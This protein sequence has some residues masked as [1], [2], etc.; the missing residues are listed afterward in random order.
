VRTALILAAGNGDRFR[1]GTR[2]SKLLQTVL[3]QPLILR[4]LQTAHEAGIAGFEIVLGYQADRVRALIDRGGPAGCPVHFTYNPAW[5]LENGVSVL[6]ARARLESVRFALLMG[7]HLFE[8]A[9]L[10]RLLRA[11]LDAGE[12]VLAVD[13]RAV[14]PEVAAEATKVRLNGSHILEIGK[15]LLEYDALDTGLFVCAPPLFDALVRAQQK[16][17]TTLSGGIR[18]LAALGLMRALDIG[19]AAWCDIDTTDDLEVAETMF[20]REPEHV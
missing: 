8:P 5:H 17:D 12:S 3:G 1:N 14:D 7:D 2:D 9:V 16:R 19:D 18:E 13:S 11:P 20:A 6:A 15:T 10:S 4:T